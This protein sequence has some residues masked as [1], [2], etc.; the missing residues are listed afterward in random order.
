M[1]SLSN[2]TVSLGE[3]TLLDDVTLDVASGTV[4]AIVGPNGAGKSTLLSVLSGERT[5]SIG[6]VRLHGVDLRTVAPT[7]LARQRAVLPQ[8]A[9]L[10]FGFTGREVAL[11]GRTPHATSRAEDERAALRALDAADVAHLA[12]R[13]YPTCSGG[14]KQRLHL[15]RVLAQLDSDEAAALLLDEP[16]SALDL[17]HQHRVLAAARRLATERGL[18]VVTVLHDLNLAAQYADRLAVLDRGRLVAEGTPA[19][20]IRP[21]TVRAVFGLDALVLDH[22]T[23]GC[24]LVVAVPSDVRDPLPVLPPS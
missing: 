6:T 22:P 1:L 4:T 20:V 2:V 9:L 5:P 23:L 24:P 11:L 16:T 8:E 7:T 19:E 15:A 10:A 13:R 21:E 17:A 14:E 3:A 12:E 18:A